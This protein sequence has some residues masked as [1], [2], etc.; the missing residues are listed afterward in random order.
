LLHAHLFEVICN[1]D[2]VAYE[3][4]S[5]WLASLVQHPEWPSEVAVVLQGDEGTGKGVLGRLLLLIFGQHGFHISQAD[6]LTGR[7]NGHLRDCCYL[8]CDDA[9]FAGD[10][11]HIGALKRLITEPTL[12]I[13]GKYQP[14]VMVRNLLH[15]VM[16]SNEAWVVPAGMQSRRFFVLAVS[17]AR[18]GDHD[19]FEALHAELDN[20]GTEAFLHDLLVHPLG[21]FNIRAVPR[22]DALDMQRHLSLRGLEAWWLDC[23]HRGYVWQSKCGRE[24][25]FHQWMNPVATELL[26]A[27]YGVYARE[28][29]ERRLVQRVEFGKFMTRMAMRQCRPQKLIVGE[30]R[31]ISGYGS[32]VEDRNR[33]NG[34]ELGTLEEARKRF[35]TAT[36]LAVDWNDAADASHRCAHGPSGFYEV[37]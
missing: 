1:R 22:T 6:H 24:E 3:Y 13:E 34:Y 10:K 16:S 37:A 5:G 9:F 31:G 17:E 36:K 12:A 33:P 2:P 35:E 29:G 23:L 14:T 8:Y 4:L 30:S 28:H 27:S 21:Q 25:E 32:T 19:Y 11:A 20:G 15:I 26:F 18:M 7:F